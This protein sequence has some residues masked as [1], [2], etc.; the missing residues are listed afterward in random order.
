MNP[1]YKNDQ[2]KTGRFV[3]V[4]GAEGENINHKPPDIM[5]QKNKVKM[6]LVDITMNFPSWLPH[7]V[8]WFSDI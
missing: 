3:D 7:Q 2:N 4:R 1:L 8:S 6:E 5:K